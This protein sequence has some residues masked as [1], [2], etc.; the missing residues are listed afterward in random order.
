MTR[1][2]TY[3]LADLHLGANYIADHRTHERRVVDFLDSIKHSARTLFLMGDVIDY[4]FEYK[5]VAPRGYLRFFGKLTELADAGVEIVWFLGNH[6]IW[7]FDYL[8]NEIGMEVVDGF[9]VREI[10]GKKFFLSH[11]D[12]V[13]KIRPG[14]KFIR[15]IF[16]NRICQKLLASVHPRWTVG[17]AHAW[18]AH[19]RGTGSPAHFRGE[20]E[21]Q[22]IFAREYLQ[23]HP[24]IDFFIFGH[25]HIARDYPLDDSTRLLMLGDCFQ[26]FTYAVFNDGK[27]EL[28]QF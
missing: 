2:A 12:G 20:N 26:Q 14:F 13:G 18:S 21:P 22:I 24:E 1:T 9:Q 4:W 19:S 23:E 7:L 3:F 28:C 11:G 10:D 25:R 16:R 8:K 15:S 6:D 27:L 5:T 17:F